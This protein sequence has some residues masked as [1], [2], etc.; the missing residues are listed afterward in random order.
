M[1]CVQYSFDERWLCTS[2]LCCVRIYVFITG[3]LPDEKDE[4]GYTKASKYI[5]SVWVKGMEGKTAAFLP[6]YNGELF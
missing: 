3:K 1:V 5:S 4:T 6:V 2:T